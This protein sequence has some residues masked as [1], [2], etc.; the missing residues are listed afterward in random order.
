M[1]FLHFSGIVFSMVIPVKLKI[2]LGIKTSY[3]I[4]TK[5]KG[6]RY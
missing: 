6:P 5:L 4:S 1:T 2:N 3:R